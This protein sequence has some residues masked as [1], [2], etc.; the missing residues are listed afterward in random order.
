MNYPTKLQMKTATMSIAQPVA[1]TVPEKKPRKANSEVRKQQNRIAS[2]NYSMSFRDVTQC[3]KST[4]T[5]RSQERS[6]SAS[7]SSS[8]CFSRTM[9]Q[10]TSKITH[11]RQALTKIDLAQYPLAT[12]AL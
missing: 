1:A 5:A 11:D 8:N 12:S 7:F 3:V 4:D 9:I 10:A 6:A 2:R